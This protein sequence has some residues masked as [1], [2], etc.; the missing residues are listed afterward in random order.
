MR[1]HR[2]LLPA[3]L[4]GLVSV[5][6]ACPALADVTIRVDKA[7][8]RMVVSVDGRERYVWPV[9][10]GLPSHET[11]SGS[12]RPFRMEATHFSKEWDDAPMPYSIFFTQ[13]GHA[14]HGSGHVRQIGRPASH[15]CVRLR[16]R[17][18][19][20]LFAL[21][22]REGL[23]H[24]HVVIEGGG[25]GLVAARPGHGARLARRPA[26]IE[27]AADLPEAWERGSWSGGAGRAVR[28]D[29]YRPSGGPV[30]AEFWS[31]E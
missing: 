31:E 5:L 7:D 18:A 10:T 13:A 6:A 25:S 11:P 19:A 23:A 1:P 12:F 21:V 2:P 4:S 30:G 17:N 26:E 29:P 14:I 28:F 3:L 16:V 22:R 9:S 15:G 27:D 24:T 8:Q 20:T